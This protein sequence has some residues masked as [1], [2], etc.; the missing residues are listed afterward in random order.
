MRHGI[1][2]Y[3][4]CSPVCSQSWRSVLA[5]LEWCWSSAGRSSYRAVSVCFLVAAEF[6]V[7]LH[8][9]L[10]LRHWF[11]EVAAE[12]DLI[13]LRGFLDRKVVQQ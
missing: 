4:R 7:G 3:D 5:H 1:Y 11:V 2:L 10:F 13:G 12:T 6:R 8:A 9:V